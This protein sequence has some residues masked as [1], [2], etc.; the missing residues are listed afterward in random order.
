MKEDNLR[1]WLGKKTAGDSYKIAN[2]VKE[3]GDFGDI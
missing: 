2:I 1:C 3:G